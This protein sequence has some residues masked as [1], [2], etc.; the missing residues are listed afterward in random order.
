MHSGSNHTPYGKLATISARILIF[1]SLK[2][3]INIGPFI[4][5]PKN[6]KKGKDEKQS[7]KKLLTV[8]TE[9]V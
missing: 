5:Y 4:I 2:A 7:V 9:L 6:I 3:N 8:I 1:T